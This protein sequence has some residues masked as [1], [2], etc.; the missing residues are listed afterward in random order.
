MDEFAGASPVLWSFW[1]NPCANALL[2][3]HD[4]GKGQSELNRPSL[5]AIGHFDKIAA[6]DGHP[7]LPLLQ[8]RLQFKPNPKL[9]VQSA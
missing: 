7:C 6:Q 1:I 4:V 3:I 8:Q 9:Q 5:E 2:V